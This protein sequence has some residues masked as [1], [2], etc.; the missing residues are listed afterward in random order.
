[1]AK[2]TSVKELSD[3]RQDVLTKSDH[4]FRMRLCV[5]YG[6]A[7]RAGAQ[8]G[9][10]IQKILYC[11]GCKKKFSELPLTNWLECEKKEAA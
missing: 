2:K 8:I 3:M 11:P 4:R 5:M 9:M 7:P 6:G 10:R 1:M